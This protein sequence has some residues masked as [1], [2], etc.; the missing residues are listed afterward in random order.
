MLIR[1]RITGT[2]GTEKIF[3]ERIDVEETDLD[4]VI[5][6]TAERHTKLMSEHAAAF[7]V[8]IEFL[9]EPNPLERFVRFGTD[10]RGMVFPI[11]IRLEEK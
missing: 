1:L 7:M 11:A 3:D 9:D 5:P 4:R 10:P 6:D 2:A 8:Q